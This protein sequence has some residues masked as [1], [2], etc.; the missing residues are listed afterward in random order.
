MKYELKQVVV[1][2]VSG[3]SATVIARAEYTFGEPQYLLRYV[4]KD[5]SATEAWWGES[6]LRG[7]P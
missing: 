2:E 4:K 7:A 6:A 1:I 3:D 5:G